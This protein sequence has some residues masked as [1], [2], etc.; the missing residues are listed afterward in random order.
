MDKQRVLDAMLPHIGEQPTK[1]EVAK[2]IVAGLTEFEI[3]MAEERF[4]E[5]K[6]EFERDLREE[7]GE[8]QDDLDTHIERAIHEAREDNK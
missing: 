6:E 7:K 5:G 1:K 3:Q 2:A 4:L 8:G